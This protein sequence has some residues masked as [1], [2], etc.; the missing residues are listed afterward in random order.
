MAGHLSEEMSQ[1]CRAGLGLAWPALDLTCLTG[2]VHTH[3][4]AL[5]SPAPPVKAFSNLALPSLSL[6]II[7]VFTSFNLPSFNSADKLNN[8]VK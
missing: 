3:I 2:E 1:L 7:E 4:S 8:N 5:C 6:S